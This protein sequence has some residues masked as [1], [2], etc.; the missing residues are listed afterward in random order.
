MSGFPAAEQWRLPRR[1]DTFGRLPFRYAAVLAATAWPLCTMRVKNVH[2]YQEVA[3]LLYGLM[4]AGA[5]SVEQAALDD[6]FSTRPVLRASVE[7]RSNVISSVC[8]LLA[9]VR[10]FEHL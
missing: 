9:P 5:G 3:V 2:R 6:V 8:G 4:S 7:A 1:S 10:S